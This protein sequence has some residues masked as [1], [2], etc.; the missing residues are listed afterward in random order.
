MPYV[1]GPV[2][3]R[4]LG[5]SLGVDPVPLKTC[6]L[7]CIYCQLGPTPSRKGTSPAFP[8][9]STI[10]D[11][12][13][14]ALESAGHVDYVTVS[15]SGEPT[16]YAGI[17]PLIRGIKAMTRVPVAVITNGILLVSGDVVHALCQC[18]VVL[19]SLDA[20]EGRAFNRIARPPRGLAVRGVIAGLAAF[21]RQFRGQLWLEVM[22]IRGLNDTPEQL[23]HLKAAID[24]IKPDRIHLNTAV[25]PPATEWALPVATARM[26][27][28]ASYLGPCCEVIA[29]HPREVPG[30]EG[31]VMTDK[32]VGAVKRRPMTLYDLAESLGAMPAQVAPCVARLVVEGAVWS[33]L[34]QGRLYY[35]SS[36]T[37]ERGVG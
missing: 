31:L 10:L 30:L 19:P 4:R 5:L 20:A 16:L 24:T 6:N 37:G 15:G 36:S 13:R 12:L 3:S 2:L 8:P 21:R 35:L 28:I 11:E 34:Y 32:I 26:A 25:R 14:E 27:E 7:N 18:D 23:N 9:L 29:D 1:Y 22:L 17:G 33:K